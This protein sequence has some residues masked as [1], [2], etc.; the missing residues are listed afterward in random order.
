MATPGV[1]I[2]CLGNSGPE[3]V[4][5]NIFQQ[6]KQ[7]CFPIAQDRFITALEKMADGLILVVKVQCVALID[8]LKDLREWRIAGF[9]QEM[10]VVAH[11]HIGIQMI[12]IAVSIDEEEL[13]K[14][15]VV[16]GFF[17]DLLALVPTRDH[18]I[19]CAFK[20]DAGFPWHE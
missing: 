15:I 5:V 2:E 19:K 4:L 11:E 9:E 8:T 1:G 6:A 14:F 16:G 7:V 13:K 10:D 12:M 3:R 20:L 17:E 18:V